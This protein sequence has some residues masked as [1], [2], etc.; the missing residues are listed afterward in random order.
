MCAA[1]AHVHQ[2]RSRRDKKRKKCSKGLDNCGHIERVTQ[3]AVRASKALSLP[4]SAM[5]AAT[6]QEP[7][8]ELYAHSPPPPAT[9]VSWV[10]SV[11]VTCSNEDV[12]SNGILDSADLDANN[13]GRLEPGNI[14]T[15]PIRAT[16][17]TAGF[18]FFDIVYAKEFTWAEVELEARV[19]VA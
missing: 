5:T 18:V 8:R 2:E 10:K 4:P 13:N 11:S 12:N 19:T 9:F 7:D 3:G 6:G 16:T 14:A 1:K 17:N 15:V